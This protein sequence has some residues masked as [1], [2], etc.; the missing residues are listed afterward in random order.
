[1]A[2]P[3]FETTLTS[4]FYEMSRI[5]KLRELSRSNLRGAP[6]CL[7]DLKGI[8]PVFGTHSMKLETFRNGLRPG[9][10]LLS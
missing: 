5:V 6:R 4:E 7:E 3:D 1:M 2:P 9:I 8:P 10:S